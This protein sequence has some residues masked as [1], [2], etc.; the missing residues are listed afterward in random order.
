MVQVFDKKF[1]NEG[2][3]QLLNE[4]GEPRVNLTEKRLGPVE[5]D[6]IDDNSK[7]L[8]IRGII[9]FLAKN[10]V[11]LTSK[12]LKEKELLKALKDKGLDLEVMINKYKKN[13]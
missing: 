8:H 12:I 2:I 1:A 13:N 5:F 6:K 3:V 11:D 10:Q 9:S 7:G 4:D